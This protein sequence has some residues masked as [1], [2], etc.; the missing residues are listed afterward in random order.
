MIDNPKKRKSSSIDGMVA[1]YVMLLHKLERTKEGMKFLETTLKNPDE[2]FM[3]RWTALRTL[4]FMWYNR[5]DI[6]ETLSK[7]SIAQ[8]VALC[9]P[10]RDMAD[11]GIEDLRKW[12]RWEMTDRV[13]KLYDMHKSAVVRRAVLRF[14]LQAQAKRP[15]AQ[16]FVKLHQKRDAEWVEETK[17]LLEL[18]IGTSK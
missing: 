5:P 13:L 11:F 6:V 7:D 9:F 8:A 12:E 17:E 2:E 16:A 18:E 14:A 10:H 4:R 3:M 1:G 15:E